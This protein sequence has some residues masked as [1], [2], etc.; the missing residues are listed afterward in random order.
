MWKAVKYG[1]FAI[2]DGAINILRD[3]YKRMLFFAAAGRFAV[4][5]FTYVNYT[6]NERK[7]KIERMSD[8]NK[9]VP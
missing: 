5:N 9:K 6:W 1:E 4:A 2:D 7:R 8:S 3:G